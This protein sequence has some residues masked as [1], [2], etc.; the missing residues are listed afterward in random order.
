MPFVDDA[1]CYIFHQHFL[2][3]SASQLTCLHNYRGEVI[4]LFGSVL[5]L[6]FLKSPSS[7]FPEIHEVD[8]WQVYTN[9]ERSRIGDKFNVISYAL[10]ELLISFGKLIGVLAASLQV[11]SSQFMLIEC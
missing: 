1:K 6:D 10:V 2:F 7:C 8:L 9:S 5:T 11:R 3:N 4:L